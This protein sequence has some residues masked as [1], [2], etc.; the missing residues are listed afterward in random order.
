MSALDMRDSGFFSGRLD[1]L[2][3]MENC[4]ALGGIRRNAFGSFSSMPFV[5][6]GEVRFDASLKDLPLSGFSGDGRPFVEGYIPAEKIFGVGSLR[7]FS[8]SLNGELITP[9]TGF[10]GYCL[11]FFERG[12]FVDCADS[13]EK[14]FMKLSSGPGLS[15]EPVYLKVPPGA[16]STLF[17]G[18]EAGWGSLALNLIRAEVGEGASLKLFLNPAGPGSR[19]IDFSA[20]L[21]KGS[22]VEVFLM[23]VEGKELVYRSCVEMKKENAGFFENS[24]FSLRGD[25]KCDACSTVIEEAGGGE[26][27]VEVR[28]INRDRSRARLTGLLKVE[29]SAVKSRSRYSGHCLKLSRESR[30]RVEPNLEIEALDIEASHAASVAPLDEEKLFYLEARGMSRGEAEKE[31]ALGFLSSL[32]KDAPETAPLV[33]KHV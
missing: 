15:L 28:A 27:R 24:L 10:G 21:D 13:A 33:E 5:D 22:R 7:D 9:R 2:I 14:G 8:K 26:A 12:L 6:G 1:R 29:K 25:E 16:S 30:A 20:F 17:L 23:R 32:L 19:F 11:S 3:N 4:P 18:L 31:I